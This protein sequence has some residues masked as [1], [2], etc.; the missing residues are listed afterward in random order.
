MSREQ[1]RA[2]IRDAVHF[3]IVKHGDHLLD[4]QAARLPRR[5]GHGEAYGV[6][7]LWL[8]FGADLFCHQ[9]Q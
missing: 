6:G 4:D 3:A 8:A 2:E 9:L 5:R 1:E 7:M